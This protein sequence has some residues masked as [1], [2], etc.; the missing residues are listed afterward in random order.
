MEKKLRLVLFLSLIILT[1]GKGLAQNASLS[2]NTL[3]TGGAALPGVAVS[4]K[5]LETGSTRS[6]TT[7]SEGNYLVSA[8]PPG[9]YELRAEMNG[10]KTS[11]R[12]SVELLVGQNAVVNFTLEIGDVRETVTTSAEP[13][14]VE[15]GTGA[16]SAVVV[17]KQIEDLPLNGRSLI[18]LTFLSAGV[19]RYTQNNKTSGLQSKG[20]LLSINGA[21][22]KANAL[23][24]DGTLLNEWLNQTQ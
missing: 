24:L 4:I 6:I 13:P 2:G 11:V 1:C 23:F 19:S 3:D 20:P 8:L 17:Q 14:L 15:T 18:D 10:F 7:D 22:P 12:P 9:K 16:A 5:N 21:R